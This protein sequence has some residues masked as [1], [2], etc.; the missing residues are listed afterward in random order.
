[1][2]IIKEK[3]HFTLGQKLALKSRPHPSEVSACKACRFIKKE[4][5]WARSALL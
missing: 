5:D 3:L 2:S 1:M 4:K